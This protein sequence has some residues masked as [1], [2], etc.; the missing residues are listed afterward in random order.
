[1]IDIEEELRAFGRRR[2]GPAD[3]ADRVIARAT[4]HRRRRLVAISMTAVIAVVLLVSVTLLRVPRPG[5][6]QVGSGQVPEAAGRPVQ[7]AMFGPHSVRLPDGTEKK[8]T[9]DPNETVTEVHRASGAWVVR[10]SNRNRELTAASLVRDNSSTLALGTA[11]VSAVPNAAGD[12]VA[13]QSRDGDDQRIDVVEVPSGR[14]LAS[15]PLLVDVASS[16]VVTGWVGPLVVLSA[17]NGDLGAVASDV[18]DP[19][20]G[21]YRL[22]M[23]GARLILG[24]AAVPGQLVSL[25]SDTGT[26]DACLSWVDPARK[27]AQVEKNCAVPLRL[28]EPAWLSPDAARVVQRQYHKV[29]AVNVYSMDV[30]EL[31][32]PEQALP[33]RLGWEDATTALILT[34]DSRPAMFRCQLDGSP[35]AEVPVPAMDGGPPLGFV[36]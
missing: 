2:Q 20:K 34:G 14:Q 8:L 16:P 30:A 32:L 19:A 1:M 6:T 3:L 7:A 10:S 13:V 31:R 18:W 24:R 4:A 21:P 27:F 29:I 25:A 12:R 36:G 5:S 28:G 17:P 22:S 35:C 26:R 11:V 33:I 9:T 15:T 23:S